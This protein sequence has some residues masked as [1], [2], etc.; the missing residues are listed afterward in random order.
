MGISV[1]KWGL[2]S[3]RFMEDGDTVSIRYLSVSEN[4]GW[5]SDL[6]PSRN[7]EYDDKPSTF[8]ATATLGIFPQTMGFNRPIKTWI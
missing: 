3:L 6:W 4:V 7:G 8:E 5:P 1:S 2:E